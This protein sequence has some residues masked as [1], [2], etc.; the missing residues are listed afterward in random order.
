MLVFRT[1]YSSLCAHVHNSTMVCGRACVCVC[2]VLVRVRLHVM[3]AGVSCSVQGHVTDTCRRR[4]QRRA[5]NRS[6]SRHESAS[7]PPCLL[8]PTPPSVHFPSSLPLAAA[9]PPLQ[10]WPDR[11]PGL[12]SQGTGCTLLRSHG[13]WCAPVTCEQ[14]YSPRISSNQPHPLH[15][16]HGQQ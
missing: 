3:A 6:L 15:H 7:A 1:A 13:L 2:S 9:R 10:P 16:H 8:S 4:V 14:H 11:A 12:C 5:A